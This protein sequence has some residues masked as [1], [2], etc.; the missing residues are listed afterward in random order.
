MRIQILRIKMLFVAIFAVVFTMTIS[1][2][3]RAAV[4]VSISIAGGV[5]VAISIVIVTFEILVDFV[6]REISNDANERRL[7]ELRFEKFN[8]LLD[9]FVLYVYDISSWSSQNLS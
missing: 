4:P 7:S 6:F 8:L 5:A 2:S 9:E 1:V 3:V